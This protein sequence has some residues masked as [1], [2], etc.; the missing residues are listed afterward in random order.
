MTRFYRNDRNP[1]SI[2][3]DYENFYI[4]L[5]TM[6]EYRQDRHHVTD[7]DSRRR[8]MISPSSCLQK[9]DNTTRSV[10]ATLLGSFPPLLQKILK[11]KFETFHYFFCF[12][13]D[14][15]C[16]KGDQ[17]K[18]LMIYLS[19]VSHR[20]CKIHRGSGNYLPDSGFI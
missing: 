7:N 15:N 8:A 9:P 5:L 19:S 14:K 13:F 2:L 3:N 10:S 12:L 17:S 20:K 1:C 18:L 16:F 11:L 6:P 4:S